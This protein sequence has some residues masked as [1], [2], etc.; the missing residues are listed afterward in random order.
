MHKQIFGF[1][2]L[3][4]SR[5]SAFN[6]GVN[7]G[8]VLGSKAIEHVNTLE[9]FLNHLYVIRSGYKQS[10][11]E[12]STF[13]SQ[14]ELHHRLVQ[15]SESLSLVRSIALFIFNDDTISILLGDPLFK[16]PGRKVCYILVIILSLAMGLFREY[17][18]HLESRGNLTFL[19]KFEQMKKPNFDKRSLKMTRIQFNK[20]RLVF[21]MIGS[22]FSL[23]MKISLPFIIA[24]SVG[25][26][27]NNESYWSTPSIILTSMFWIGFEVHAFYFAACGVIVVAVHI[28]MVFP[29]YY[30]QM[31]S[32]VELLQ[33]FTVKEESVTHEVL[34]GLSLNTIRFMN[35]FD[36]LNNQLK[37]LTAYVFVIFSFMGDYIIFSA[38]VLSESSTILST[39]MLFFGFSDL[40]V[41]GLTTFV[42]GGFITKLE[43]V[44]TLYLRLMIKSKTKL[45]QRFKPF[46]ILSRIKGPYNGFQIGDLL[47]ADKAIFVYGK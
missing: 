4:A 24:F 19:S 17:A 27:L 2:S 6:D 26:R 28:I 47:T 31:L 14:F 20:F 33:K 25:V 5:S 12:R 1:Q 23:F 3:N 39:L 29:I 38:T 32:L 34:R 46:E 10:K 22:F 41:I 7:D 36:H 40:M 43:V 45:T 21:L 37:H 30:Y 16:F 13:M 8:N 35:E 42:L 44:Y 11:D 18:L 9:Y 15:L